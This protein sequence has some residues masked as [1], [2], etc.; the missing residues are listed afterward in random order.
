MYF[1]IGEL[2][3]T[4]GCSI[5]TGGIE[6]LPV[7][8]P[9]VLEDWPVTPAAD[10]DR[11]TTV[12]GWRG[13]FGPIE[14]E[15][16]RYGLKL[17]EFR[18]MIELPR[19]SPQR[20]ELALSIDPADAADRERLLEC[21][22]DLVD[23]AVAAGSPDAFRAYVQGSGA[24]FSV[25][26]GIYVDTACGWFSDR[27]VRYLAS[28]KPALVQETGFSETLGSGEG[29]LSFANIAQ[30]SAGAAAIVERYAEH[31]A[32]ARRLAEQH[33]DSD[34]IL[35]WFCERAGIE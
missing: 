19:R 22:W 20:F 21:G 30:A 1:T 6:W 17:H 26:Q 10:H 14:H 25:A 4:P 32:A 23:P 15:G 16:R 13:P 18:K 7:R 34:R 29:L 9:V 11:F 8:Q 24:E 2:I 35:A 31:A 12:G 28:G 33:F 3:G 5:P 27:T